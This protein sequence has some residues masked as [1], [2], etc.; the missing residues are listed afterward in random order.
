MLS[1]DPFNPQLLDL[2]RNQGFVT[3]DT[4]AQR[5]AV[6][7]Q[8][9]RRRV[10]LLC[11]QGLLRRVHGGVSMP[12]AANQPYSHRQVQ[13]LVP[14]QRIA[15]AVARMLPDGC[16]VSLGLGTTPAQVAL[17]LRARRDLRVITNSINV[18]NALSGRPDIELTMA[19]GTLRAA[20]LDVVGSAAARCFEAFKTDYAVFG[21]GGIDEDGALL[22]FDM[23]EVVAR[24]AMAE[25]CRQ[26]VLVADVSKFGRPALVRGGV[27]HDVDHVVLDAPPPAAYLPLF[28]DDG[29]TL[30]VAAAPSLVT[31]ELSA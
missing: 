30:H 17:A 16:S 22:D 20:D 9:I 14:K 3:I 10:N 25:N 21:V 8:T 12:A 28:D 11:D 2:V 6:T 5:F 26:V 23:G 7:P 13:H 18:V 19:G 24:Q 4:L 27:L 15:A 1:A 29:L 31:E